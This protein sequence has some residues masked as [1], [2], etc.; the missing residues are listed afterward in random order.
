MGNHCSTVGTDIDR[1]IVVII[2]S[3]VNNEYMDNNSTPLNTDKLKSNMMSIESN[4]T[5]VEMPSIF[6]KYNI[7]LGIS[8]LA[9]IAG[10]SFWIFVNFML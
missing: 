1:I 9:F 7:I 5:H 4:K 8:I 10:F 3:L 6:N 2:S